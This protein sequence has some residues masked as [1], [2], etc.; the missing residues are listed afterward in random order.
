MGT[1]HSWYDKGGAICSVALLL[2]G[3]ALVI[4]GTA[5]LTVGPEPLPEGA[6]LRWPCTLLRLHSLD[7][8]CKQMLQVKLSN[9]TEL[10][11]S[12]YTSISS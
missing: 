6:A 7:S 11:E 10:Q 12:G 8:D 4:Y 2:L 9:G 5:W 1:G 3:S